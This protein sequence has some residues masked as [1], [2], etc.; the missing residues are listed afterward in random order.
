MIKSV[1]VVVLWTCLI[2]VVV[3]KH[4]LHVAELIWVAFC[5]L[6]LHSLLLIHES[7]QQHDHSMSIVVV[8]AVGISQRICHGLDS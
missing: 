8:A 2:L 1:V 3:K 5:A 6:L 4:L 7:V